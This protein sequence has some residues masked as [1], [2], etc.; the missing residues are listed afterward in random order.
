MVINQNIQ[1]H[2]M[3]FLHLLHCS[4]F[5]SAVLINMIAVLIT[6][7]TVTVVGVVAFVYFKD[8]DPLYNGDI[9]KGDQVR[10]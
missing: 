7:T 4:I 9:T 2:R 10:C 6:Y 1:K 3:V 5:S 8:C